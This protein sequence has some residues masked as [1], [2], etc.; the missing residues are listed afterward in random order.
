MKRE[1][2][3]EKSKMGY[4]ILR[5]EEPV[6]KYGFIHKIMFPD[7]SEAWISDKGWTLKTPKGT[8]FGIPWKEVNAIVKESSLRQ[9]K[10]ESPKYKSMKPK[11]KEG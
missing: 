5:A 10:I 7:K 6:E 2:E 4:D 11:R 3:V 8:E 9:Q 1:I